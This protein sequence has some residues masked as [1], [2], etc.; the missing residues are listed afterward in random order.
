[1]RTTRRQFIR[2]AS[3]LGAVTALKGS[4]FAQ[5]LAPKP[6]DIL[7]L[8][9]TGFITH[10]ATVWPEHDISVWQLLQAGDYRAAQQ[11]IM[12]YMPL[13]FMVFLYNFSAGL[14][15]YWTVSNLLSILQ[16]WMIARQLEAAS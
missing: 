13:M 4:A 16:Q 2:G 5:G 6:L 3:A 12:K 15:L 9:G 7:V 8:G 14:T 10:L 1:M 11:K